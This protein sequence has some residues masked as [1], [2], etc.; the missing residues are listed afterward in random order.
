[1]GSRA[2]VES[3]GVVGCDQLSRPTGDPAQPAAL[4]DFEID[5][6]AYGRSVADWKVPECDVAAGWSRDFWRT[7]ES[8]ME[9]LGPSAPEMAIPGAWVF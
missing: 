7:I 1:M 2:G 4:D 8:E 3:H 6:F 9:I 5:G